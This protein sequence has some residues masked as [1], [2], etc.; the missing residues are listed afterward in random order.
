MVIVNKTDKRNVLILKVE[1]EDVNTIILNTDIDEN[2][3]LK[4]IYEDF[5]NLFSEN[6]LEYAFAYNRISREDIT[7]KHREAA[8]SLIK[9]YE[10]EKLKYYFDNNI[11]EDKWD[12][13]FLN[14]YNRKGIFSEIILHMVLKEFKGTIPLVS[15]VYFKDSFSHEAYG[16]DSVHVSSDGSALWLG[17]TK[18]YKNYKTNGIIKGGIEELIEDL[19]KHIKKDYLSEQFIVI[20]RGL[21][22]QY[23]HPQR[24]KWIQELE[25]AVVL[26]DLFKY[27]N[28]PLLCIYEDDIAKDLLSDIEEELK[29]EKICTHTISVK[30]YFDELNSFKFK[31][32]L[33][34]ILI[35]MPVEEK[36]KLIKYMLEKIWHMQSI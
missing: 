30:Q 8:Q 27:I 26:K 15:K 6:I 28:V 31:E 2:G 13:S 17:E 5:A 22:P 3:E 36:N 35:L 14:W 16:F 10:V 32:Q 12:P 9:L 25:K 29:N 11:P 1:E 33:Q 23:E 18:F 4:Y 34:T 7:K 19:K 20:K 24:S 21:E